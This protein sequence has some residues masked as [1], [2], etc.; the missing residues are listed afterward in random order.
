MTR[1][2]STDLLNQ[3]NIIK[4]ELLGVSSSL[5]D[6]EGVVADGG[7]DVGKGGR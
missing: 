5:L 1:I 2:F 4:K 3:N 7:D 6:H